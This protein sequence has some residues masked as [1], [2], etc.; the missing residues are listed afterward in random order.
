MYAN[1]L[2]TGGILIEGLIL[3]RGIKARMLDKYRVF[4]AYVGAMLAIELL[5]AIVAAW[6]G[7]RGDA[8]Y[9]AYYLPNILIPLGQ[10]AVLWDLYRRIIG[11]SEIA[12]RRKFQVGIL[13]CVMLA[14]VLLRIQSGELNDFFYAYQ[15][16]ALLVQVVL[17]L[18]ACQAIYDRR[19]HIAIG[20]NLAG[21][22][23]GLG[24]MVALQSI[25]FARYLF[26]D[27]DFVLFSFGAQFIYFLSLVV[28]AWKLWEFEP[29]RRLEVS[30][31]QRLEIVGTHLRQVLRS[32]RLP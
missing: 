7:V 16:V 12:W 28:F 14:P 10:L 32:L 24:L 17:C 31:V 25:N 9:Y 20:R 26:R 3:L 13:L 18:L 23:L 8:Y 30:E 1:L 21:I 5:R 4:Y 6:S 27:H 15:V 22:L 2:W 11:Y 29:I 19:A